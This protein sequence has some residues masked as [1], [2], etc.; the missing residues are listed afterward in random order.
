MSII[1]KYHIRFCD[2]TN[3][4]YEEVRNP[5]CPGRKLTREEAHERIKELGLVKVH[6]NRWGTIW[7]TPNQDFLMKYEGVRITL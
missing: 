3:V 5:N 4:T 7:D 2:M 6:H 1:I